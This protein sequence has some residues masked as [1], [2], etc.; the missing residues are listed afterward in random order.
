[1]FTGTPS[2]PTG[3]TGVTQSANNNS[4]ALSTTAYA[5]TA[6]ANAKNAPYDLSGDAYGALTSGQTIFRFIAPRALTLTALTSG[7]GASVKVQVA[8]GDVTLPGTVNVASGNLVAVLTT[9]TGTDAY[10]TIT[11]KVA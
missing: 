11:G 9:S 8:G 6:A 1:M 5:D 2:L 10:F 3:T 4:T 7:G